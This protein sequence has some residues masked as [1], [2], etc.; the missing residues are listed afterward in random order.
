MIKVHWPAASL[1]QRVFRGMLGRRKRDQRLREEAAAVELQRFGRGM[2]RRR[3]WKGV[4]HARLEGRMA[5]KLQ[6]VGRGYIDRELIKLRRRRKHQQEVVIPAAILIQS[7]WRGY[8]QRSRLAEHRRRWYAALSLQLAWKGVLFKR[9]ARR[10]WREWIL[11]HRA[12]QATCIQCL[13][14]V[15]AAKK[16]YLE[17]RTDATWK[18][19]FASRQDRSTNTEVIL[20]AWNRY[21]M[22]TKFAELLERRRL[23]KT[24]IGVVSTQEEI[25]EV[26]DDLEATYEDI[27]DMEAGVARAKKRIKAIKD[28]VN[29]ADLRLVK[30]EE[31]MEGLELEDIESG[32][33]ENYDNEWDM[34]QNCINMSQEET[35]VL[36]CVIADK[37]KSIE[38]FKIE[39]DDLEEDLDESSEKQLGYLNTLR[40]MEVQHGIDSHA[41]DRRR[42]I[43]YE[44]VKWAIRTNRRNIMKRT[45]ESDPSRVALK[46]EVRARRSQEDELTL[47]YEQRR[48]AE[49]DEE[50]EVKL[51]EKERRAKQYQQL[52]ERGEL[53]Q[54]LRTTYDAVISSTLD[55]LKESSLELSV[56]KQDYREKQMCLVCGAPMCGRTQCSKCQGKAAA[57]AEG[58]EA[59]PYK[60]GRK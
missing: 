28:F 37:E 18:R 10:N 51:L 17:L 20:R 22:G 5:T 46:E 26:L 7:N 47:S 31:E 3:W 36:K 49:R 55:I 43:R 41:R 25:D 57:A 16:A 52:Q 48:D 1:M 30:V 50:Y 54:E 9:E 19:T 40:N 32:W 14:R 21:R 2:V 12:Y 6:G 23:E 56:H 35:R 60:M 13:Y 38:M 33:G 53:N 34:L 11:R 4:V 15:H 44:K 27:K 8:V 29:E 39:I 42:S 45:R 59:Q 58:E 24:A